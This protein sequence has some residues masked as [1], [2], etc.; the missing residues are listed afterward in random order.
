MSLSS[1]CWDICRCCVFRERDKLQTI[2]DV[3][4]CQPELCRS[5]V[6]GNEWVFGTDNMAAGLLSMDNMAA[7]IGLS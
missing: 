2:A 4:Y 3:E 7:V 6:F 1:F 5:W